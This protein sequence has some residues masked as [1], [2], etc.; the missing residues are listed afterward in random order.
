M[1]QK[2]KEAIRDAEPND[3]CR[4]PSGRKFCGKNT[5]GSHTVQKAALDEIAEEGRVLTTKW[6]NPVRPGGG[7][8]RPEEREPEWVYTK[9]ASVEQLL[10]R[11]HDRE[12]FG[13]VERKEFRGSQEQYRV[14]LLRSTLLELHGKRRQTIIS[15]RQMRERQRGMG[16]DIDFP[17][18]DYVKAC[19]RA[20]RKLKKEVKANQP[21]GHPARTKVRG[22]T[23][24]LEH[25]PHVM[26]SGAFYPEVDGA[27]RTLQNLGTQ[28]PG[29]GLIA[30]ASGTQGKHGWMCVATREERDGEREI[31]LER[32]EEI[33]M[34]APGQQ[35][36]AMLQMAFTV[37]ENLYMAPKWWRKLPE[38][39]RENIWALAKISMFD[40]AMWEEPKLVQDW[41]EWRAREQK[42]GRGEQKDGDSNGGN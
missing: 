18:D 35:L 11:E 36:G 7:W 30:W 9:Q 1:T 42:K 21:G 31:G 40:P 33:G 41:G 5:V 27:G 37:C 34:M 13:E 14:I 15:K 3:G 10:C 12:L 25:P 23:L 4:A 22:V 2:A 17:I 32:V 20:G 28:K 8:I 29:R 16:S 6:R 26:G 39:A 24:L 38:E 19:Q